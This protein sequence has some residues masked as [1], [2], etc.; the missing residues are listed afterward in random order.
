VQRV[1]PWLRLDGDAYPVV[2]DGRILWVVDGYTTLNSL[3]YAQQQ[4]FGGAA[5]DSYV[6]Q[7]SSVAQS[8]GSIDYI[9]NSIK[10]TVDAYTGKVTLYRWDTETGAPDPVLQTWMKA[11]PHLVQ[12]ASAIPPGLVPH[13]RYP[14]DLFNVQRTLLTRY[15][16]SDPRA[17]YS[18]SDFWRVPT[19]PT[20]PANVA[21]PSFYLSLS[22]TGRTTPA[23]F[24]L[25]T[26]FV[27]LNGRNLT[28]YL[29]V[30]SDPGPG[31][32]R[33][34]LVEPGPGVEGP[35]QVRNDIESDPAVAQQLTLLRG[36]GSRVVLG[37]LQS[38][39][40]G[41]GVLSIE[42]IYSRAAGG[43]SFPILH[44]VV[45]VYGDR[46]GFEPTLSAALDAVFGLT[47]GGSSAQLRAAVAAAQQA[48]GQAEAALAAGNRAAYRQAE[49]RLAAALAEI[50]A[51]LARSSG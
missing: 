19:D 49:R 1:A 16:V 5:T 35:G 32:G 42:P 26:P 43:T 25:T 29:S 9:R 33:M 11:F 21:Q 2:S 14:R 7:G 30:D 24:A 13:L 17:F 39:P 50:A 10:A 47:P 23:Q 6:A 45:A 28:A 40:L 22:T 48:Q 8:N 38:V 15:H 18:G 46:V 51:A 31:Y 12:P 36:G 20:T 41:D 3:P 34:T 44:D 27:S 37:N 4:S